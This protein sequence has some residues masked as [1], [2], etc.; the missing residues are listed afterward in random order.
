MK[1][2][3][4]PAVLVAVVAAL[5]LAVVGTAAAQEA[6]PDKPWP[7][8]GGRGEGLF[9]QHMW[10]V[11]DAVAEALGLSP[12]T[13]FSELHGGK[14]VE[15]LAEARN[16]D[17]DQ[18]QEAIQGLRLEQ[19]RARIE[20]AVQDGQI[21]RQRAD[22]MLEGLE[23]GFGPFGPGHGRFGGG[24]CSGKPAATGAG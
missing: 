8:F 21:T 15:E 23:Q 1:K 11:F 7:P 17:M 14:T 19:Q 22:W 3:W 18:V 2:Y 10:Q 20:Q 5:S 4:K 16:V 12:Q 13:L 9:S 6:N 24:N